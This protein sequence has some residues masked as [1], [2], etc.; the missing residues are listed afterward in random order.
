MKTLLAFLTGLLLILATF[1]HWAEAET[2]PVQ[3]VIVKHKQASTLEQQ[4][5]AKLG[6]ARN[7]EV[8]VQHVITRIS[9][10][11]DSLKK[12]RLQQ[13][14]SRLDS[15]A[16]YAYKKKLCDKEQ[17]CFLLL[18]PVVDQDNND[19][20]GGVSSGVCDYFSD[21]NYAY[22]IIRMRN[23]SKQ[24]RLFTSITSVAHEIGHL[25]GAEHDEGSKPYIMHPAALSFGEKILKWSS[26]SKLYIKTCN[27]D[28]FIDPVIRSNKKI[29]EALNH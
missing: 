27:S 22:A 8:G 19:Y 9:V 13:Y 20:G 14:V 1:A 18:P 10:V 21:K 26:D 29:V 25:N 11:N 17:Y 7:K 12:N 3:I 2:I 23:S 6:F 5:I 28:R 24:S 15:W 4:Q 16:N